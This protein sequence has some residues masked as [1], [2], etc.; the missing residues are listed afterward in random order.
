LTSTHLATYLA[1]ILLAALTVAAWAIK[2]TKTEA[3]GTVPL[4]KQTPS[5]AKTQQKSGQKSAK[6]PAAPKKPADKAAKSAAKAKKDL[7]LLDDE[8]ETK[9]AEGA[10]NS[11][12][13]VCHINF[14]A[15]KLAAT[16]A[17]AGVGCAKCHGPSDAHIDDESWASG[18][19]GTPPDIMYPAAKINRFCITCHEL[20]PRDPDRKCTFPGPSGKKV[21][22]DCHGQHRLKTRKCK[23]K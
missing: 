1:V 19:K 3:Q 5:P 8:P 10:D 7:L 2:Q 6:S 14:S 22:T 18:G 21:C 13:H 9:P 20:N 16:H 12:C 11:R 23:W 15:E 17:K 4:E